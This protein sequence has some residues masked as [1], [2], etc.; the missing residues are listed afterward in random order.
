ML[1]TILIIAFVFLSSGILLSRYETYR[2][3]KKRRE[4]L[5]NRTRKAI[6]SDRRY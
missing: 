2:E 3:R 5:L 1:I 4:R 6:R